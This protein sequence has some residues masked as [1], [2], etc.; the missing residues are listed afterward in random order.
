MT[1]TIFFVTALLFQYQTVSFS[2]LSGE[3]KNSENLVAL[4]RSEFTRPVE[5]GREYRYCQ[6]FLIVNLLYFLTWV[7]CMTTTNEKLA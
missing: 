2:I 5:Y 1:F 7:E 3:K 4:H 6:L